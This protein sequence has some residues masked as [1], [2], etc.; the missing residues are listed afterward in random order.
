MRAAQRGLTS[1]LSLW[2]DTAAPAPDAPPLEGEVSA[3]VAIVG[4][5][6]TGCAAA[7]RLAEKGL[8]CRLLEAAAFGEGGSGRNA[9]L[10]NAGLWLPPREVERVLGKEGA[11]RLMGPLAGGPARV[12]SLIEQ[13]QMQCEATRKGT[14]HAAHAASGFAD[15]QR[16]F[17]QWRELG[18]PV[19]LLDAGETASRSGAQG[20]H[21]GLFDARAGTINP[22]GYLRGL[23]RAAQNAG[24]VLHGDSPA[25]SLERKEGG[26]RVATARGAVTAESVILATNAY[27]G[28]LYPALPRA[29]TP[30]SYFQVAS[31]PLGPRAETILPGREGVW[32]TGTIMTSFRVDAAGRLILGSMGALYGRD[33]STSRRWADKKARQLFPELGPIEWETA[34]A[35][36]IAMT[37]DHLPR[38]L[39]PEPGLFVP[40]GYNGRGIGPGTIFGEALADYLAEGGEERLPL[41]LSPSWRE[42]WRGLRQTFYAAAF[43]G[44]R[45]LKSL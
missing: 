13:H 38:I 45:L 10:V 8:D 30:I 9:G 32:D 22:M 24:A 15:L 40:I 36:R 37:G 3:K 20:F 33:A 5:G 19:E 43:A 11:K 28:A 1:T 27:S 26:W 35:G 6:F 16:R 34:W 21:G 7:L 18:A 12:F 44:Y 29:F 42:P 31:K 25:L 14:I 41:P 23:A 4:G 17:E 2:R 39:N